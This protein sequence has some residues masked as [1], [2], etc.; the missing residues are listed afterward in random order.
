[1][2]SS[3]FQQASTPLFDDCAGANCAVATL[4]SHEESL[5]DI[6]TDVWRC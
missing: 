6:L 5:A 3:R 4:L 2:K 1:M